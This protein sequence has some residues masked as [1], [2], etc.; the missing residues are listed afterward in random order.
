VRAQ[1]LK[2]GKLDL[3]DFYTPTGE[4]LTLSAMRERDAAAFAKIAA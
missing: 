3:E 1:L 4:W 2:D